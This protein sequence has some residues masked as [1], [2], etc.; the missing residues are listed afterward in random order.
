MYNL[1]TGFATANSPWYYFSS[2]EAWMGGYN[3]NWIADQE[4]ERRCGAH[5]EHSL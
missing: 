4:A 2:D 3:N 5:E 1:A